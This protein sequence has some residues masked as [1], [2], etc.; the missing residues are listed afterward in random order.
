MPRPRLDDKLAKRLTPDEATRILHR[1][2]GDGEAVPPPWLTARGAKVWEQVAPGLAAANLTQGIDSNILAMYCEAHA[3]WQ[4]ESRRQL[5]K[6]NDALVSKWFKLAAFLADKLGMSP[7]ARVAIR[8]TA[9]DRVN[10]IDEF[11]IA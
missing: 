8:I 7:K 11:R 4:R 5:K 3:N 6:R 9:E 1:P 2:E 10:S